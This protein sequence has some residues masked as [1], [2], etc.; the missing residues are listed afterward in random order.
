MKNIAVVAVRDQPIKI[1]D[2]RTTFRTADVSE[3]LGPINFI[4]INDSH[5]TLVMQITEGSSTQDASIPKHFE[6]TGTKS[7]P[8]FKTLMDSNKLTFLLLAV[9]TDEAAYADQM[10]GLLTANGHA[11]YII[12]GDEVFASSDFP[13]LANA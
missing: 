12:I 4:R 2:L 11:D 10:L 5:G 7:S 8:E 1:E 6:K 9:N 3:N 13:G